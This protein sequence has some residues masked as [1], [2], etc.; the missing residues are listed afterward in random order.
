M[1]KLEEKVKA[2]VD[3]ADEYELGL[4]TTDGRLLSSER[5]AT[6][7]IERVFDSGDAGRAGLKVTITVR[8]E[9]DTWFVTCSG[10]ERTL[11]FKEAMR[12]PKIGSVQKAVKEALDKE[13]SFNVVL[14]DED[15]DPLLDKYDVDAPLSRV[16]G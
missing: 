8:F 7:P 1:R 15:G 13:D 3:P 10:L 12:P 5:V 16:F 6:T 14:V 9:G 4:I 11:M 2:E